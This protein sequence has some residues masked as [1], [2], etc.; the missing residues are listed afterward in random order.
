MTMMKRLI[1]FFDECRKHIVYILIILLLAA[2]SFTA[3][4]RCSNVSKEYKHNIEAMKDTIKYYHDKNGNLVATKLAYESDIKTLKLLNEDLYNQIDSLKLRP[5]HINQIVHFDGEISNEPKDTA[6]VVLH[7]TIS[8]GF[9]KEFDFNNDYRTLE[10]N[11]SY[12]QDSLN[13]GITKDV[14]KF[15]YVVAI[16]KDSRIYIKSTN[17]YVKYNEISGFTI[18]KQKQKRWWTGPSIGIGYDPSRN[19]AAPIIGWSVGYG[20]FGW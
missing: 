13:V 12:A 16:D 15:D 3:I 1:Q 10:G 8:R 4:Q 20:L 5:T 14:V 19:N 17:P 9:F 11:V 2:L 18:P 7:D 6:Y